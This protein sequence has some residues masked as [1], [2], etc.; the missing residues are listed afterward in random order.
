LKVNSTLTTL[1]LDGN[2]IGAFPIKW[3]MNRVLT[4]NLQG[5][6]IEDADGTVRPWFLVE[7]FIKDFYY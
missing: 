2:S 7:K 1:N 5:N 3:S 4:L 6:S